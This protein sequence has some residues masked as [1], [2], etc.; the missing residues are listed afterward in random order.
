MYT[1][2]AAFVTVLLLGAAAVLAVAGLWV[3]GVAAVQALRNLR[4]D[5]RRL[6][7][8]PPVIVLASPFTRRGLRA[9][10]RC[11]RAAALALVCLLVLWAVWRGTGLEPA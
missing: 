2:G 9:R 8:F 10:R 1:D 3:A 11:L 4:P 6:R 7:Y 5:Y